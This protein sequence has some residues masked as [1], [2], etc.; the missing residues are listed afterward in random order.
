MQQWKLQK[1]K[2]GEILAV[3]EEL[4]NKIRIGSTKPTSYANFKTKS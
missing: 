1:E 2:K 4:E 3:L